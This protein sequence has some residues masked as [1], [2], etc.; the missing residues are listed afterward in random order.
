[1]PSLRLKG[2]EV[3]VQLIK[4]NLVQADI[5]DVRS[6]DVSIQMETMSEGYLGELT[7]R[8]DDVFRG[9]SGTIAFHIE[10][11]A[12]FDL[13]QSIVDRAKRRVPG[14]QINV[15]G[16]LRFPNGQQKLIVVNDVYFGE[17]PFN[18]G[19]RTDYVEFS[20]PFEAADIRFL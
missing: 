11:T 15:K 5:T 4:D 17:I 1:M 20:L 7:D 18:V 12:A 9:C 13:F 16:A 14:T 10:N 8:R 3:S 2:Q 19:G 6:F